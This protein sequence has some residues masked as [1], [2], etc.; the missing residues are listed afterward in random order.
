MGMF[1]YRAV[2][3]AVDGFATHCSGTCDELFYR[4]PARPASLS[5]FSRLSFLDIHL[6]PQADPYPEAAD[7]ASSEWSLVRGTV[8]VGEYGAAKGVYHG[9][10]V[11]AAYAM[12]DLQV[13]TCRDGFAGW[14]FWTFD[15]TDSPE[16]QGL[17]TQQDDRGAINGVLA[18]IVRPDPCQP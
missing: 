14:L 9:D 13:A 11:A 8:I 17:F 12:R 10:I 18:P 3:K 1:T 2:G 6:Y 4:Y 7:L 5:A 16:Q 15:T